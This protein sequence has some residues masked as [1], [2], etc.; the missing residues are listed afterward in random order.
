MAQFNEN[1]K[2][3]DDTLANSFSFLDGEMVSFTIILLLVL[4]SSFGIRYLSPNVLRLFDNSLFN[5]IVLFIIVYASRRNPTVGLIAGIS[6]LL[7]IQQ[8]NKFKAVATSLDAPIAY[9]ATE[10]MDDI[11]MMSQ[12][13]NEMVLE[14]ITQPEIMMQQD[15]VANI[16]AEEKSQPGCVKANYRNSYYPSYVNMKPDAYLA[17]YNNIDHDAYDPDA[18]YAKLS[19][20]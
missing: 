7:T 8:L 5:F 20:N 19:R 6:F 14:D 18:D 10:P 2:S 12:Q 1:I 17:R 16:Q 4:Y 15:Q 3:F 13:N 9:Q 11:A